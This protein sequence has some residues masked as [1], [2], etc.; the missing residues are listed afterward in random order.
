[1]WEYYLK[2]FCIKRKFEVLFVSIYIHNYADNQDKPQM[3]FGVNCIQVCIQTCLQRTDQVCLEVIFYS[4]EK[5]KSTGQ[6]CR[7]LCQ[8][9]FNSQIASL[10]KALVRVILHIL[11]W[12]LYSLRLTFTLSVHQWRFKNHR[13]SRVCSER[14]G[15]SLA[16]ATVLDNMRNMN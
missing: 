11:L 3:N 4:I 15:H 2:F 5:K 9:C 14:K 6:S 12:R 16:Q 10:S 13:K 1:M 8:T 7:P